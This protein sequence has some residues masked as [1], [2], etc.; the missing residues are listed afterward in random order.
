ML[1]DTYFTR[2]ACSITASAFHSIASSHSWIST[3]AISVYALVL[4]ILFRNLNVTLI[5][6]GFTDLTI[7]DQICSACVRE[8]LEYRIELHAFAQDFPVQINSLFMYAVLNVILVSESPDIREAI[9]RQAQCVYMNFS[10]WTCALQCDDWARHS[11]RNLYQ[12]FNSTKSITNRGNSMS[13]L[14]VTIRFLDPSTS[15]LSTMSYRIKSKGFSSHSAACYFIPQKGKISVRTPA[16]SQSNRLTEAKLWRLFIK[17]MRKKVRFD[18]E[19]RWG[20]YASL[21]G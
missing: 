15:I 8:K 7:S 12:K 5:G 3:T 16:S 11:A 13:K 14:I 19:K 4:V 2:C 9:G 20:T 1:D 18:E 17:A 6:P 21:H 10:G